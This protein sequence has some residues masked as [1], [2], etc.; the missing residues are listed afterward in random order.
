VNNSYTVLRTPVKI[1]DDA[2]VPAYA[3]KLTQGE[4]QLLVSRQGNLYLTNGHGGFLSFKI[5]GAYS[6]AYIDTLINNLIQQDTDMKSA[7]DLFKQTTNHSIS[8]LDQQSTLH[9]NDIND[10][11]IDINNIETS[12]IPASRIIVDVPILGV[13][14]KLSLQNVIDNI[15]VSVGGYIIPASTGVTECGTTECGA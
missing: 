6:P 3:A 5:N 13:T 9:E 10:I 7:F 1:G 4:E 2:N 15:L 12:D 14:Q 8:I 11:K